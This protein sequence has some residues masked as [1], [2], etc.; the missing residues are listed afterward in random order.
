[1]QSMSRIGRNARN[2]EAFNR[3]GF[4]S[5]LARRFFFA[6]AFEIYGGVSCHC[7]HSVGLTSFLQELLVYM[8]L[9][10]LVPRCSPISWLPGDSTSSLRT[11]CWN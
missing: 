10:R 11:I 7:G 6:P 1:M 3:D 8:T 9:A 5:L 2:A 4:T